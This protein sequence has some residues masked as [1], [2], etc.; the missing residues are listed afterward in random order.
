LVR[1]REFR[2]R[3]SLPRSGGVD[4]RTRGRDQYRSR[5]HDAGRG[6]C[7]GPAG[8][9]LAAEASKMFFHAPWLIPFSPWMGAMFGMVAGALIRRPV[10]I[11]RHSVALQPDRCRRWINMLA[12]G[13]TPFLCKLFYGQTGNTTSIRSRKNFTPRHCIC[14]GFSCWPV[15]SGSGTRVT[16]CGL[17]FAGEHPHALESAGI[18][19]NRVR[20]FAVLCSGALAGLGG[21]SLSI[22]LSSSFSRI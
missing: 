10:W 19:V 5:R 3:L 22:F 7:R 4:E 14:P 9:L 6:L 2:R 13:L 11:A 18:R 16:A 17:S 12:L 20:W 1:P 8:T 21:A 15:S